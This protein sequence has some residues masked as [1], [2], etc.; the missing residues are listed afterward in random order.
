MIEMVISIS[1]ALLT[2]CTLYKKVISLLDETYKLSIKTAIMPIV[3]SILF[4]AIGFCTFFAYTQ[5][6]LASIF[7]S[8]MVADSY[9]ILNMLWQLFDLNTSIGE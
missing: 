4:S 1:V 7:I 2:Y 3:L 8:V 5:N 6:Y 9:L